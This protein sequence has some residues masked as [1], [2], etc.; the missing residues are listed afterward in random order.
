MKTLKE[1]FLKYTIVIAIA[2][3][4]DCL[5]NEIS[6]SVFYNLIENILFAKVLVCTHYLFTNKLL[7]KLFFII[8]YLVFS[9]SIC[10][11]TIY[12]YLF[13]TIFSSSTVFVILDTNKVE[14][15]EFI[16]FYI[17]TPIIVF[18]IIIL[19]AIAM[20]LSS[21][22]HINFENKTQIKA[23]KI[24]MISVLF[25]ILFFFKFSQLIIYNLPYMTVRASVEYFKESKKLGHYANNKYGNF[26][27]VSTDFAI[28]QQEIYIIIIGESTA[29][30]HLG[31]YNYYRNTTPLLQEIQDELLIYNHVIS[32]DA[33]TIASLTKVLTL[34]N[35]E[36]LQAKYQG[37][38][39]QLLNQAKFKTYWI[40][41]Q[42]PIG[43][44]DSHVT[45]IAL[46]AHTSFFL[47]IKHSREKT[48]FDEVLVEKMNEILL[49]QGN[50]KVIFLHTL[51]THVNY[52]NR[53]PKKFEI[54]NNEVPKTKFKK[55]HIYDE[56]NAYDNAVTYT[57]Y[58]I[59][60]VIESIRKLKS[61]SFV[62]YFSDHGEE[63]YDDIEF[64]GHFRDQLRTKNVYEIPMILWR[65]EN[66][67]NQRKIHPHINSKYMIDDMFHS[68]ADL[69]NVRAKEVDSTRSIFNKH[70]KERKR[71]VRDTVD[72]DM[73]FE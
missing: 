34:G 63:V 19:L 71:I 10:I 12:Y 56:I 50:K 13:Q 30:S 73:F 48:V 20:T 45:K 21:L 67:K 54:F 28:D 39:I 46:G 8:S 62:L 44:N 52:K 15:I 69:L 60:A 27:E 26:N 4:F 49:E 53:Y 36:N 38:I 2:F 14:G 58:I 66:Y 23:F 42:K 72:Y 9:I 3:L 64:S 40:S 6:E 51:G 33:Y 59:R 25:G 7:N 1:I 17:N 22:K 32:P 68:I 37:S 24:K 43:A 35:Y 18:I 65:S 5:F 47:N 16:D 70:F 57:D 55:E 11:E 61:N 31:I 29:R 41:N